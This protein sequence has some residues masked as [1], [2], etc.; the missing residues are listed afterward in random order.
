MNERRCL[1][2]STVLSIETISQDGSYRGELT[3]WMGELLLN[4]EQVVYR[5]PGGE[6]AMETLRAAHGRIWRA[7]MYWLCWRTLG[8]DSGKA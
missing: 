7:N 5:G 3:A 6:R 8:K 2:G 1:V 4:C